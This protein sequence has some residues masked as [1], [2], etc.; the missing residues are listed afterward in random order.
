MAGDERAVVLDH[1][2]K[3]LQETLVQHERNDTYANYSFGIGKRLTITLC[4][5]NFLEEISRLSQR[6]S[7]LPFFGFIIES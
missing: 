3:I 6:L 7:F 1:L 5:D 4:D 2:L